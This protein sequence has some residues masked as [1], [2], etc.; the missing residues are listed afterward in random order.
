MRKREANRLLASLQKSRRAAGAGG[1]GAKMIPDKIRRCASGVERRRHASLGRRFGK[2]Q[3]P[4]ENSGKGKV[5]GVI[6]SELEAAGFEDT[7]AAVVVTV[8]GV[9]AVVMLSFATA[10]QQTRAGP[11]AM[12]GGRQPSCQHQDRPD[13]PCHFHRSHP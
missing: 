5:R 6:F 13:K 11:Q 12:R 9:L 1:A 3:R 2:L 10:W 4:S 7:L 8:G